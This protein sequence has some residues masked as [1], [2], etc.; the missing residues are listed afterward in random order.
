MPLA[1]DVSLDRLAEMTHGFVGADLAALCR[2]AAMSTLRGV[3]DDIPLDA[4]H[5]PFDLLARLEVK[6]S[7]FMDALN[8]VEPSALREVFTEVPDVGWDDV[9]GL[10]DAKMALRQVIEWPLQYPEL[11]EQAGSTPPRGVLLTGPTG[12]GKTL[13]AKAVANE[14]HVNFIAIKGP[15]LLSK[16]VGES[17]RTVREVFKLARLSSPC[18]VFF[19]EIEAIASR[20]S[21]SDA[22]VNERVISQLLAEMDGIEELRGV[23]VLAATNR[24]DLLDTALLRAGRFELRLDLPLPDEA[25]RLAILEVHAKDKP[26]AGDVDLS[27]IAAASE[28]LNGADLEALVRRAA[29]EAIREVLEADEKRLVVNLTQAHLQRALEALMATNKT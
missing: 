23:V 2:E 22:G 25:A 8:E 27:A 28:G 20:R 11:F 5:I 19:D 29:L 21:G 6:M 7:D 1:E 26:L 10:E 16:W 3:A 15:E 9:G 17:E 18:I 14:C 24:P 12:S 13:L 4:E